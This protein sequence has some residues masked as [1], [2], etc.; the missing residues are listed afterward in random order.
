H[1]VRSVNVYEIFPLRL[2]GLRDFPAITD[3]LRCT[4]ASGRSAGSLENQT[5]F[6][7]KNDSF[8]TAQEAITERHDLVCR[9]RVA[10]RLPERKGH[11]KPDAL[12]DHGS[13]SLRLTVGNGD[14]TFAEDDVSVPGT[15]PGPVKAADLNGDGTLDAVIV[16]NGGNMAVTVLLNT[17]NYGNGVP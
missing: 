5:K 10:L 11:G 16:S 13:S 9:G 17:G 2:P 7:R 14:G 4:G 8:L 1:D 3:L 12:V 15:N 6:L